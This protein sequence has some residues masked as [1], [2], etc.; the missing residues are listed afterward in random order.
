MCV[1]HIIGR[2]LP[3]V[4]GEFIGEKVVWGIDVTYDGSRLIA[5][6][7]GKSQTMVFDVIVY[8]GCM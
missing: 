2:Y 1:F 4:D 3:T 7:A 6:S 5:A 8:I